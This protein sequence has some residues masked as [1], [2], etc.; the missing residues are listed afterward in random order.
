[1]LNLISYSRHHQDEPTSAAER[2][3]SA[4]P[5]L[6]QQS[7]NSDRRRAVERWLRLASRS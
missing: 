6:W 5:K 1:M 2:N 7:G 4:M 3:P